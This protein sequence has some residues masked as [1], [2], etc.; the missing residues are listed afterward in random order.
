MSGCAQ[1]A[2]ESPVHTRASQ[3]AESIEIMM[4]K[5]DSLNR[6]SGSGYHN[7]QIMNDDP[8]H[9]GPDPVEYIDAMD[10]VNAFVGK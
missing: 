5:Y 7:R 6:L 10:H 1:I 3:L 2:H 4:L 8:E 9:W